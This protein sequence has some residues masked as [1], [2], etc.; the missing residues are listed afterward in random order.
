MIR[1]LPIKHSH[2]TTHYHQGCLGESQ[3]VPMSTRPM[4]TVTHVNSYPCQLV[5]PIDVNSYHKGCQLVPQVMSTRTQ[6]GRYQIMVRLDI[7]YHTAY[8]NS[9]PCQLVP[10]MS[11]RTI[12]RCQLVPK[13][14]PED[15][16]CR[17]GA[18]NGTYLFS[19]WVTKYHKLN[20]CN[21]KHL[22]IICV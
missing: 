22:R 4:S 17:F 2:P 9:Y 19:Y 7:S 15:N 14:I 20:K 1:N 13:L 10:L 11:I 6:Q 18:H 16:E 3:L 12:I 5:P 21:Q 8:V